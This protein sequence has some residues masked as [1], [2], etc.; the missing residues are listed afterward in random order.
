MMLERKPWARRLLIFQL[1]IAWPFSWVLWARGGA[2][3]L[4]SA[5]IVLWL[6]TAACVAGILAYRRAAD[7]DLVRRQ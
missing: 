1:V 6:S 5:V 3:T 4:A 2:G 7:T